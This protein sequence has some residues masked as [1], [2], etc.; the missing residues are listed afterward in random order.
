VIRLTAAKAPVSQRRMP[1]LGTFG[2]GLAGI[3]VP[4]CM[5]VY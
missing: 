3:S 4:L 2:C 1:I 5:K